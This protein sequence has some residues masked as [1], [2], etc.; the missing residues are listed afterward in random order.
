MPVARRLV[1]EAEPVKA[2]ERFNRAFEGRRVSVFDAGD[3][4]ADLLLR[5]TGP[6]LQAI[7]HRLSLLARHT[8]ADDPR[9]MDHRRSD[10]AVDLLLG[11]A[12]SAIPTS[13]L[14]SGDVQSRSD[15]AHVEKGLR[16]R[17]PMVR[18]GEG[19]GAQINITVPIQT[20]MGA[21]DAPGEL[22]NGEPVPAG[23]ARRIAADP[24]STWFRMLTDGAG[25]L[26]DL[27]TKAYRAS[28]PLLG[29]IIARDRTCPAPGCTTSAQTG[30]TDHT[31]PAAEGGETS[32]RNTGRPCAT[33]HTARGS[34]GFTLSQPS[35]GVFVWR[36][37]TGHIYVTKPEPHPVADWPDHWHEPVSAT[38]LQDALQ[39]HDLNRRRQHNQRLRDTTRRIL[40]ARLQKWYAS[41]P[42]DRDEDADPH[43]EPDLDPDTA[44]TLG[45]L[46]ERAALS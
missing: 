24:S 36:Y 37:P 34:P 9:S 28:A 45:T 4:M 44:R 40:E 12:T 15:A 22:L 18:R 25:N 23:L 39:M 26:L 16:E 33:H 5:H 21:S 1:A 7:S 19:V 35:P 27:S 17:E 10:L 20:L 46:L 42:D 32:Y 38:Q 30:E 3:G 8:G 2:E 6:E 31:R 14:E 13:S 43:Y 11:H 41:C 29:A